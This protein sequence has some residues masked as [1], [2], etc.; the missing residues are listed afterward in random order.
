MHKWELPKELKLFGALR[1]GAVLREA[2]SK[3]E[4]NNMR[5]ALVLT[6]SLCT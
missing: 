5:S 2:E 4:V 3:L 6:D 1:P